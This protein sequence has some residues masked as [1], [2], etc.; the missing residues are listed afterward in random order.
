MMPSFGSFSKKSGLSLPSTRRRSSGRGGYGDD[1]R[2]ALHS[3]EEEEPS[4]PVRYSANT[5]ANGRARSSSTLSASQVSLA[6]GPSVDPPSMRRTKTTPGK[7][8]GHYVKALYD[9]PGTAADELPLRAGQVVEVK[10]EVSDDWWIGEFEGR[11]GLFPKTYCEE[12]VP[13]PTTIV[14]PPRQRTLPPPAGAPVKRTIAPSVPMPMSI[15]ERPSMEYQTDDSYEDH[16]IFDDGDENASTSLSTAPAPTPQSLPRPNLLPPIKK[17]APPPPPASRR[18]QS[19]SNLMTI[20]NT[21]NTNN[22]NVLNGH[23]SFAPPSSI[24]RKP[25]A[26]TLESSPEGSP[27]GGSGDEHDDFD[28]HPQATAPPKAPVPTRQL[29]HGLSSMHISSVGAGGGGGGEGIATS[30]KECDCDGF[31]QNVFKVKG[32]CANCFHVH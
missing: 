28:F 23:Q 25:F 20:G 8:D 32:T 27:F 19:S 1:D 3:E 22:N 9:F 17:A 2:M 26:H 11:S 31:R 14:P 30:C 13:T 29:S 4:S 6:P 21:N 12:Y 18:S 24:G 15:P 5:N 10:K 7:M 16:S